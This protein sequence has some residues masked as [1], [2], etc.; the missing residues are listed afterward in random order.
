M[1]NSDVT[2][3]VPHMLGLKEAAAE[4]GLTYY[5]LRKLCLSGQV[6]SVR[7]G[8]KILVN[9]DR[10]IDYLNGDGGGQHGITGNSLTLHG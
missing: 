8:G 1:R 6:V 3:T 4:T 7:C 10:L 5:F 2:R 9:M